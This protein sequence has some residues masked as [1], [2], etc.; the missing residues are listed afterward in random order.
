VGSGC[1]KPMY[2]QS[3]AT[4]YPLL[5]EIH[6]GLCAGIQHFCLPDMAPDKQLLRGCI[7]AALQARQQS[8]SLAAEVRQDVRAG[9]PLRL[10][11]LQRRRR[12]TGRRGAWPRRPWRLWFLLPLG[13]VYVRDGFLK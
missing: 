6:D 1:S 12:S 7:T 4:A 9:G 11:R 8:S 2:L 5:H 3:A 13:P 10:V